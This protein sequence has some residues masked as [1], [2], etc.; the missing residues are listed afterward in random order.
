MLPRPSMYSSG[1]KECKRNDFS[2]IMNRGIAFFFFFSAPLPPVSD[3]VRDVFS[4][5]AT[6]ALRFSTCSESWTF[7]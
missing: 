2:V 3:P 7:Y 5:A 4:P 6:P 1:I